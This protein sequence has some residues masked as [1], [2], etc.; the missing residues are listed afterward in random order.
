MYVNSRPHVHPRIP[1]NLAKRQ[2]ACALCLHMLAD[3]KGVRAR[4]MQEWS[5]WLLEAGPSAMQGAADACDILRG[6]VLWEQVS[7]DTLCLDQLQHEIL[8]LPDTLTS[9]QHQTL[10][11]SDTSMRMRVSLHLLGCRL[12]ARAF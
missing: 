2:R 9:F 4:T 12:I 3:P 10:M 11:S 8:S 7:L 1:L 5:Q 6:V